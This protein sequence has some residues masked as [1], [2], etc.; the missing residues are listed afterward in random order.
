MNETDAILDKLSREDKRLAN[1]YLEFVGE[2]YIDHSLSTG[3]YKLIR[4]VDVIHI[5]QQDPG[6]P[7]QK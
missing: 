5:R 4:S 2:A 6:E 1:V 3:E 7:C